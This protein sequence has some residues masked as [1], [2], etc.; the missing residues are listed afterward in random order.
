MWFQPALGT[1]WGSRAVPTIP[2]LRQNGNDSKPPELCVPQLDEMSL[3]TRQG[4]AESA[5]FSRGSTPSPVWDRAAAVPQFPGLFPSW[6]LQQAPPAKPQSEP[7]IK[8]NPPYGGSLLKEMG[9]TSLHWV[10]VVVQSEGKHSLW[11]GSSQALG[12]NGHLWST[13][14]ETWERRAF[15][16]PCWQD[17]FSSWPYIRTG[18]VLIIPITSQVLI[19]VTVLDKYNFYLSIILFY[20]FIE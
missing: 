2:H 4:S 16:I 19:T 3:K 17:Y 8:T 1:G 12:K 7:C 11:N 20:I 6:N 18:V 15:L 14:T 5:D 10:F 13:S 9:K